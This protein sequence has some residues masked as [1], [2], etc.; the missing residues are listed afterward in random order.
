MQDHAGQNTSRG[1]H[2]CPAGSRRTCPPAPAAVCCRSHRSAAPPGRAGSH[3]GP[4]AKPRLPVSGTRTTAK[5]THPGTVQAAGRDFWWRWEWFCLVLFPPSANRVAP[6]RGWATGLWCDIS[7]PGKTPQHTPRPT[8]PKWWADW[9]PL[10]PMGGASQWPGVGST[11][12]I[13]RAAD[14]LV[15]GFF[16]GAEDHFPCG[17]PRGWVSAWAKTPPTP[18]TR[19]PDPFF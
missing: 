10:N 19:R 9:V 4:P 16:F 15:H 17:L 13:S 11:S 3:G 5:L 1:L 12:R 14:F 2:L 7:V 8:P 6:R 18:P